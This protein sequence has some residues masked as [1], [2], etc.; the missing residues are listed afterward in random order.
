MTIEKVIIKNKAKYEE[1]SHAKKGDAFSI[2][3]IKKREI[4]KKLLY[5]NFFIIIFY[6][7]ES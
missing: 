7:G 5:N 4:I 6:I 1:T 3:I 2:V